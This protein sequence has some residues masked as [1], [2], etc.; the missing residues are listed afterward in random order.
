VLGRKKNHGLL[1]RKKI[2]SLLYCQKVILIAEVH[3]NKNGIICDFIDRIIIPNPNEGASSDEGDARI[4]F[5]DSTQIC[6]LDL[7]LIKNISFFKTFQM[8]QRKW[9]YQLNFEIYHCQR[10]YLEKY[11]A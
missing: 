9:T 10:K 3:C 8:E 7:F 5:S 2:F 11:N 6:T 1:S 4:D